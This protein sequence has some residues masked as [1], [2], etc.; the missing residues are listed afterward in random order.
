MQAE[1]NLPGV[2]E[3][4]R[5]F[6]MTSRTLRR[7]LET[8]QT[9]YQGILDDVRRLRALRYLA[10]NHSVQ[11]VSWLL[12]YADPSNFSRAFRKWTGEAPSAFLPQS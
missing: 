10:D 1:V 9:T 4:A 7:R 6:H 2:E 3:L 5:R 11:Q 8:A 12:G